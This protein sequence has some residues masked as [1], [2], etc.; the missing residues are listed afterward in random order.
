MRY[1]RCLDL[2]YSSYFP[3]VDTSQSE[4][5]TVCVTREFMYTSRN[6]GPC[7]LGYFSSRARKESRDNANLEGTGE[8]TVGSV[9]SIRYSL[10]TASLSANRTLRSV[11]Y[12]IT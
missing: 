11:L 1:P 7:E 8:I 5:F 9:L 4:D 12:V 10:M 6:D 3:L 2:G